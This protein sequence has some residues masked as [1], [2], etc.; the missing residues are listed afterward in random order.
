VEAATL[1]RFWAML[2]HYHA[3]VWNGSE[4][5]R[6]FGVTDKTVRHYLDILAGAL[7]LRVLPPWHANLG[8]RQV[9][10]PKIYLTDTGILH[11]LLG[12]REWRDLERHPKLGA[13]W[14]GLLLQQ[15]TDWL[16]AESR[17]CF[18]W[19]THA[20][21]EIDLVWIRGRRRWGFEFK[22]TASPALTRSLMTARET[23][24]LQRTFVVHAGDRSFPLHEGVTAIAA[25]RLLEDLPRP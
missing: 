3:Q 11:E 5:A 6:S 16:G 10:A 9:K 8:K 21:A 19:A 15:V 12:I 24:G 18:F 2:A 4:F 20:G 25:A 23:L 7:V 22:R 1:G 17:D 13:S 14:E